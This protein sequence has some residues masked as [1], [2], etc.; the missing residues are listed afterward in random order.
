MIVI[1]NIAGQTYAVVGLGKSGL[2]TAA[3][4][5]SS[6]AIPLLWDDG[7][8]ARDAAAQQGYQIADPLTLDWTGI[9]A[10]ILSPGIPLTH[11]APHPAVMAARAA[12]IPVQGDVDLLFQACPTARYVGITG[13]N[14]KS[15][16]TALIGHIL[17]EAGLPVQVGGNLG[18]PVLAFDALG[19]DG[20]YVLELSSYQLDLLWHNRLDVAVFLNLTPDHLDRH[21]DMAGYLAAKA[22]IIRQDAPQ[23]L[24][25]GTDEPETQALFT[26]IRSQANLTIEEISVRHKVAQGVMAEGDLMF[27]CSTNNHRQALDFNE[28]ATLRGLHNQQNVCAAYAACRALGVD[29]AKILSGIKSFPGL[30]HRQQLVATIKNAIFINDSKA[31]NADAAAKALAS[32]D[33]IYWIIGGK[34]KAGGLNGLESFAPKIQHAFIIGAAEAEFAAWCEGKVAY[35]RSHDLATAVQQAAD[36]AWH[37]GLTGATVLLSPACA[38]FD[39][40]KS[41]EERGSHF[42]ALVNQLTKVHS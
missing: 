27:Q 14:G 22:R 29:E 9:T 11:P 18:T 26:R 35:T 15:T 41:F 17:A 37:D 39:Q 28:L 3:A 32:Y 24:V 31:T 23:T 21:G 20:I 25:L 5:R 36:H 13:T 40:F 4:L 42:I 16:T 34:P 30:V 2:A 10:L 33:N 8:A 7:V 19:T 38:S 12:N 6:R 1:P